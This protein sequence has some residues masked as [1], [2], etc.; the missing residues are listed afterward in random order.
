MSWFGSFAVARLPRYWRR[1]SPRW[2]ERRRIVMDGYYRER[3]QS[4]WVGDDTVLA[5]V[6]GRYKMYVDARDMSVAA[7]LMTNGYWEIGVTE[8]LNAVLRRP[9]T[10][11]DVGA[12]HGYFSL[13]MAEKCRAGKVHSFECNPRLSDLL[14]RNVL[15]NGIGHQVV[16][17]DYPL[18]AEDGRELYLVWEDEL[19]GG[20]HLIEQAAIAGRRHLTLQTRRLDA[21]E[22]ARD[23]DAVKIDAEGSEPAIWEGMAG[24]IA[25][26]RLH[27]VFLEF[28]P[29]RYPDPAAFLRRIT[30]AGFALAYID[31]M[32]GIV[33]ATT[34]DILNGSRHEWMLLLRR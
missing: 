28:A 29:I 14:R 4:V 30:D 24:M 26:T 9:M 10:V 5:T 20:G 22:G 11:C 13:V 19:S 6:L 16:R 31:D 32:R 12:N 25:G 1:L 2:N 21:I 17:H 34:D 18:G 33:S 8:A 7:H 3:C 23:A 15:V 27:I